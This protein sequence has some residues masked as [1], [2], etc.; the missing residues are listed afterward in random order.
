MKSSAR[1][2]KCDKKRG[3]GAYYPRKTVRQSSMRKNHACLFAFVLLAVF[4][5]CTSAPRRTDGSCSREL[6]APG[7]KSADQLAQFFLSHNGDVRQADILRLARYYVAEAAAEGI[8][9]D[10]AFVQMCLETGWLQF[11]NLVT[12]DMYNFCGLGAM[13]AEHPGEYF[14]TEQLG[15]RAHIQHLQAYATTEDVK[16]HHALVDPRY[17]WVHKAKFARTVSDLA[18]QWATDKQYGEKLDRLLAELETF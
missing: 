8:N 12:P 14:P 7:V 13:D 9:A 17:D 11:G 18:G 16:L 10:V 15:V 4:F 5:S 1:I 2:K 3:R 6:R